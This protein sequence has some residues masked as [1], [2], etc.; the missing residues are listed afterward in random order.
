[1][2]NSLV[3]LA[4]P[5]MA[6]RLFGKDS[7]I[8]DTLPLPEVLRFLRRITALS[9]NRYRKVLRGRI[10]SVTKLQTKVDQSYAGKF[11]RMCLIHTLISVVALQNGDFTPVLIRG[12]LRDTQSLLLK[13]SLFKDKSRKVRCAEYKEQLEEMHATVLKRGPAI[14]NSSTY[15]H[16]Q[17]PT[18]HISINDPY[19]LD[20]VH[21]IT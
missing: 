9:F 2:D 17:N 13:L 3:A 12:Y 15:P 10:A 19:L 20:F 18:L 7:M 4:Y 8:E 6:I 16:L 21:N 5:E 14:I 11:G 1:M